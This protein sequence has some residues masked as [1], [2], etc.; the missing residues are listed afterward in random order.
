MA[1]SFYGNQLINQL[2]VFCIYKNVRLEEFVKSYEITKSIWKIGE[3]SAQIK[4]SASQGKQAY[5]IS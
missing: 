1:S 2:L 5:V 4:A 3:K